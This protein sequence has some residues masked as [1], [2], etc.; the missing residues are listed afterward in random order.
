MW[1]IERESIGHVEK[2]RIVTGTGVLSF[3]DVIA[4]W[5]GDERFRAFF[6]DALAAT[7]FPA[8]FWEMPPVRQDTL[9]RDFEYVA[10]RG[11]SLARMKADGSAFAA[12]LNAAS[13]SVISF[14][15][16]GG[17]A[18]LVVPRPAGER[19]AYAHIATFSRSAP[20]EQKHALLR[21][22][23]VSIQSL[24]EKSRDFIWISTS[25]LGVPW[26]H[27]RLDSVPKYYQHKPYARI[28]VW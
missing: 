12:Q 14:P 28:E 25:G 9:E 22:L 8:F 18:L 1:R 15:N 6:I 20:M 16:L 17:D 21:V 5:R 13:E 27:V 23:A 11:D 3:A 7:P 26:V 24:L 19:Q 2:V 4:G 10:V